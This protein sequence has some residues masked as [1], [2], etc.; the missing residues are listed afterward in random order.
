LS[1][2]P[3]W[4]KQLQSL[5]TQQPGVLVTVSQI[6]GSA[7]R[8][9]GCRMIVTANSCSGN[10]E[11]LAIQQAREGLKQSAVVRQQLQ[12]VGFGPALSP[13]CG[14]VVSLH[15]EMLPKGFP[16]WLGLIG[17]ATK[18]KRFVQ[19]LKRNGIPELQLQRLIC[20]I[21]LVGLHG[22]QPATIALSLVAQLMMMSN[23]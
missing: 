8:E 4:A 16:N 1:G 9:P 23:R 15:F 19:R 7:P 10:P 11:Y 22:K 3:H 17:S 14:G 12:T 18:R 5:L 20:P 2:H 6:M 13:C 21:G